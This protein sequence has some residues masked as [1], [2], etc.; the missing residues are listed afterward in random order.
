MILWVVDD[1]IGG[2]VEIVDAGES[3]DVADGTERAAILSHPRMPGL[4]A[5]LCFARRFCVTGRTRFA[6]VHA[7]SMSKRRP[8]PSDLFDARWG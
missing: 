3:W 5:G 2:V 7:G 6:A 4:R 8:Y 1:G